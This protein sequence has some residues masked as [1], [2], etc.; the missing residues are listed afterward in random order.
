VV[1]AVPLLLFA[2]GARRVPL[3]VVGLL[4]FITP[5]LQFLVGVAILHEPMPPARWIGFGLVWIALILLT[6]DSLRS[7]RRSRAA[8]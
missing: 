6:I 5:I 4:Q 1:T 8:A 2:S 3:T 7:V